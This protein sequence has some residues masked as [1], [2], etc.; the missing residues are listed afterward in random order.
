MQSHKQKRTKVFISYSHQDS[1]WLKRLRI[2]LKPLEREFDIEIWDDTKI[3]PGSMW[4]KEIEQAIQSAKVAV[5]LISADFL[6]SD[7]ITTD[8]LP[9]LLKAAKEEGAIILSVILSHSRFLK[10]NSLAQFQAVNDPNQPLDSLLRPEQERILVTVT[11]YIETALYTP[12]DSELK[13]QQVK[14]LTDP[15]REP[16]IKVEPG[17]VQNIDEESSKKLEA[18]PETRNIPIRETKSKAQSLKVSSG[19][20]EPAVIKEYNSPT[21]FLPP[22]VGPSVEKESSPLGSQGST[23]S[24]RAPS[25]E[26]SF[27]SINGSPDLPEL[28][29]IERETS[30]EKE[31]LTSDSQTVDKRSSEV[32]EL[33]HSQEQKEEQEKIDVDSNEALNHSDQQQGATAHNENIAA[34]TASHRGE[35][36]TALKPI[37]ELQD[38]R[39]LAIIGLAV[40]LS[41]LLIVSIFLY[42]LTQKPDASPKIENS[43]VASTSNIPNMEDGGNSNINTSIVEPT[44]SPTVPDSEPTPIK[45]K[46]EKLTP[47]RILRKSGGVL[48]GSAITRVT[49]VYPPVARAARVSGAVVV[50]VTVDEVGNVMSARAISGHTMLKDAAVAAARGWKFTPTQL[51]GVPVKVVGNITFNFNL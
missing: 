33:S 14:T 31:P 30:M 18:L 17:Q 46:Q 40:G 7:F 42:L 19:K 11:D 29:E 2:H 25:A 10:I 47:P 39:R 15:V 38:G 20:N 35:I 50:E 13:E 8:E 16:P 1:D 37:S 32:I 26:H 5:L 34:I 12:F 9:P 41:I 36:A 49:P 44:S 3:K 51:G 48:E 24:I 45:P 21:S 4:K 27:P 43:N 6:A 23:D 28:S 22:H